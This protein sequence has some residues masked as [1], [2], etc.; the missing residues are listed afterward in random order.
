M[1]ETSK[2]HI[3]YTGEALENGAMDINDLAPALLAFADLVKRANVLVGNTQPV[4]LMLNADS[5]KRGSFDVT[6]ELI[7]S[8]LDQI[9]LLMGAAEDI[10]LKALSDALGIGATIKEGVFWLIQAIGNKKILN[11]SE[12][13][14][15]KVAINLNDNSK[16]IINQNTYNVFMDHEARSSITKVM[17][18]VKKEGIEGFEIRNPYNYKDKKPSFK[19][20]KDDLQLYETPELETNVVP[21]NIIEQEVLLKIVS[22]VFDEAQKWRFTDGDTTFWAKVEDKDFWNSVN[23]SEQAFRNGDRLKAVCKIVQRVGANGNITAERSIIKVIEVLPKPTQ[24][25]LK[26]E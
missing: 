8:G 5:I 20:V 15:N 10:G 12:T 21:E 23:S 25:K 22:L 13:D 1:A 17:E 16:I 9:K 7:Y 3:A 11:V 18:P 24:I 6:L 19:V 4:R 14:D 26:L 2:V